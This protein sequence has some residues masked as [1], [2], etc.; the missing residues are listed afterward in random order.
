MGRV[1]FAV[2]QLE[3]AVKKYNMRGAAIGG[4]VAGSEAYQDALAARVTA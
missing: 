4:N 1:S 3:T 2:Q